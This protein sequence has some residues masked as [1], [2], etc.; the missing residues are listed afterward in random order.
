MRI[1][2]KKSLL[3]FWCKL[4]AAL[5]LFPVLSYP[6]SLCTDHI[7]RN[8][9]L[10]AYEDKLRILA[11]TEGRKT[12]FVGGSSVLFGLSA[13][14]YEALSG[15]KTVNMGL[16]AGPYDVYL[17]SIEEYVGQGDTVILALEFEAY[18]SEWYKMDQTY[19]DLA[20]VTKGYAK[21]IPLRL[22]PEY[23]FKTT[24]NCYRRAY[25]LMYQQ[26]QSVLDD[27][28]Q[29][30][31]RDLVNDYGDVKQDRLTA[32]KEVEAHQVSFAVEEES[33]AMIL[34]YVARYE[35]KGAKV[36]LIHPP[37]YWVENDELAEYEEALRNCFGH[38][39]L[40]KASDWLFTENHCFYDTPYHLKPSGIQQRTEYLY[41]LI[42]QEN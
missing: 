2:K 37:C 29:L 30:Y 40:G 34:D 31:R 10:N 6:L 9:Y 11:Q 4:L 14:Q 13:E 21:S 18:G 12:M 36:Y 27:D 23:C 17:A 41:E 24:L 19:L 28:D 25:T 5:L 1:S 16:N 39:V 32:P 33:M 20:H 42:S 8:G 35:E 3:R 22:L 7:L 26:V 38:R 15:E